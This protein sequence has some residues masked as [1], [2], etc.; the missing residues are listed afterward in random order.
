[1]NLCI[2]NEDY[3]QCNVSRKTIKA[4]PGRGQGPLSHLE[5]GHAI[6]FL[7][8]ISVVHVNLSVA[9]THTL[10]AGVGIIW[11]P[12]T[13]TQGYETQLWTIY[14]LGWSMCISSGKGRRHRVLFGKVVG[15]VGF[16]REGDFFQ[17]HPLLQPIC[18]CT[19]FSKQEPYSLS[20]ASAPIS[21]ARVEQ[22]RATRVLTARS[23]L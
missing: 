13:G 3:P 10:L 6:P 4:C 8:R 23:H 21:W 9:A 16:Q 22:L 1:M 20:Q 17:G 15:C 2:V 12:G 7:H 18:N 11:W 14:Q 19:F 5:S